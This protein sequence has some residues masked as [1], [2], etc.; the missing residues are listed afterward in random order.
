MIATK[1]TKLVITLSY[2]GL[3]CWDCF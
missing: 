3:V 2:K 1:Y